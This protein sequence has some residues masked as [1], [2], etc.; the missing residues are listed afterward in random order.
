MIGTTKSHQKEKKSKT[1]SVIKPP[2]D[3]FRVIIPAVGFSSNILQFNYQM[4][5]V[6]KA[7]YGID[8][9]CAEGARFYWPCRE[10][11]CHTSGKSYRA[12]KPASTEVLLKKIE[13]LKKNDRELGRAGFIPHD[14]LAFIKYGVSQGQR[15]PSLFKFAA[16][17][18]RYG[19]SRDEIMSKLLE[20]PFY[21]E[22][23]KIHDMMR[24]IERGISYGKNN[25]GYSV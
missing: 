4:K 5:R 8:S 15:R 1:S 23:L 3:R 18:T 24:Q 11:V 21:K 10:I 19:W 16:K 7:F 6:A 2:V 9:S 22:D 17:L 25:E 14:V 13:Q 20:A 12:V